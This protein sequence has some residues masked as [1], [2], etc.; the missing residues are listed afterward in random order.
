MPEPITES[1][2][3]K[4]LYRRWKDLTAYIAIGTALIILI[5]A[6]VHF[7]WNED[8]FMNS[9]IVTSNTLILFGGFVAN[10]RSLWRKS[11]FWALMSL[12]V[13]GHLLLVSTILIRYE[14]WKPFWWYEL[15]MAELLVLLFCRTCLVSLYL[16]HTK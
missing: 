1:A 9:V 14:R 16:K 11:F 5:F 12:L 10:S 8:V 13:L 4:P 6:S 2:H 7:G 15:T 3:L